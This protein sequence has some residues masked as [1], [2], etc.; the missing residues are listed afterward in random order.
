MDEKQRQNLVDDLENEIWN[1][2]QE[3]RE[4]NSILWNEITSWLEMNDD[5]LEE[6]KSEGFEEVTEEKINKLNEFVIILD[7]VIGFAEEEMYRIEDK[8][9]EYLNKKLIK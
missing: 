4:P 9:E 1:I 8:Y 5:D 6:I 2:F 7:N 3:I